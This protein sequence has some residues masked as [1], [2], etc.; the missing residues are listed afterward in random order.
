MLQL[1]IPAP[2]KGWC[3]GK[4]EVWVAE[5]E[6][7]QAISQSVFAPCLGMQCPPPPATWQP[8][9]CKH[10]QRPGPITQAFTST[11]N[12][13][14]MKAGLSW[15][16]LHPQNAPRR[17]IACCPL[18]LWPCLWWATSSFCE[19]TLSPRLI[20]RISSLKKKR[21]NNK[22]KKRRTFQVDQFAGF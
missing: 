20:Q 14:K 3:G 10:S 5:E 16:A 12:H 18:L 9:H 17:V 11:L 22:F 19:I 2:K 13:Q 21:N 6:R 15:V 7:R 1:A 8:W 4:H